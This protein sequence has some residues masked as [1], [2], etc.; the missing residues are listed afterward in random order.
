MFWIKYVVF[1]WMNRIK[2][3]FRATM[4][5]MV[6]VLDCLTCLQKEYSDVVDGILIKIYAVFVNLECLWIELINWDVKVGSKN[7]CRWFIFY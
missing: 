1:N 2:Y 3:L 6:E 5:S 4:K 7:I